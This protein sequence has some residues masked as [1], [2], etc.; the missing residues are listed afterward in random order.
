MD[1]FYTLPKVTKTCVEA[2]GDLSGFECIIEPSAGSGSFL[3]RLKQLHPNVVGYDID[4]PVEDGIIK[5]DF[6]KLTTLPTDR[7]ILV[8][9]NP[10]F[11]RQ[12]S[13]AVKF[14]NHSAGFPQV[15]CITMI[16][17]KSFKKTSVQN[18]LSLDFTLFQSLDLPDKAFH[19]PNG[20]FKEVPCVFQIW[21]RIEPPRQRIT[22]QALDSAEFDF[23]SSPFSP[24]TIALRRVGHYAGKAQPYTT[25]ESLSDRMSKP[26]GDG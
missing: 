19:L 17:P 23:V 10:P 11:G 22:P 14:F 1:K 2:V 9:G 18:R 5:Q 16:F 6:L 21:K 13:M 7:N 20:V 25:F 3:R 8:I 15:V 24:L 4:P 12:A 26:R